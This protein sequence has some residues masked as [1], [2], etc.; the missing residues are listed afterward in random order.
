MHDGYVREPLPRTGI[1]PEVNLLVS[2]FKAANAA[3]V[4]D[5]LAAASELFLLRGSKQL[6]HLPVVIKSEDEV[7]LI[8]NAVLEI[9]GRYP[10]ATNAREIS[11]LADAIE[12]SAVYNNILQFT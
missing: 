3:N 1:S 9:G 8:E 7:E 4:P 11:K 6:M 10:G 12:G 5:E 2:C